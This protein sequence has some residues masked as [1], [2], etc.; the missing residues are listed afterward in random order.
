MI[1]NIE[2]LRKTISW[3][4][5]LS[6]I[7]YICIPH[8]RNGYESEFIEIFGYVLIIIGTL[9]RIWCSVYIGGNKNIKLIT[10]GPFSICRN[11]L[12]VFSFFGAIGILVGSTH[13][14]IVMVFVPVYWL[15]YLIVVKAEEKLLR[16][17]FGT[18]FEQYCRQVSRFLPAVRRYHT[19]E[20]IEVYPQKI[21]N[22]IISSMW[23]LWMII[24][25]EVIKLYNE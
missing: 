25:L 16:R 17:D 2:R 4:V 1:E 20:K 8:A 12:Y 10:D 21:F 23:F 15:Y 22:T 24:I 6:F 19:R 7:V 3:I 14:N 18:E 9:G 11:P 13:L 5:S